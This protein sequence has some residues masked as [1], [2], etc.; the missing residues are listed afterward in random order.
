MNSQDQTD[1]YWAKLM[2]EAAVSLS[3]ASDAEL[4]VQLFNVLE[5][6]F[7]GSNCWREALSIVVIPN[8][9]D[10][11]L[12]VLS[13]RILRLWG[14]YDQNNVGQPAVMPCIGTVRFL[15]PYSD[16]QPMTAVVVKTATDP[17]ACFPPNIPDWL[18]PVHGLGLL[19]GLLGNMMQQP[20]QSYSNPQLAMFHLQKFRDAIA[21]AR[22]AAMK[23]N[24]VGAQSWA[25]PQQFRV[26]GQKG[27]VSTFNVH[28]TPR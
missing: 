11:Q 3:G 19:H 15:Y 25:F 12:F 13:G 21:H 26:F 1:A 17:L 28:P 18:L 27:G 2:G 6:F 8:T 16:T 7:D 23:M 20:G 24:A 10:Y 22:V 9:M 14:V 4:R 5:E